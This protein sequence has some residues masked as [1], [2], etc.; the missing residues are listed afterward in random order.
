MGVFNSEKVRKM[1]ILVTG[2]NG[3][4][5][6]HLIDRLLKEGHEI[7]ALVRK[8]GHREKDVNWLTGD[9]LKPETLPELPAIDKAFYLVHGLKE[10][11]GSFEY[12]EA[13]A[14]VNFLK[15][16]R[17]SKPDL[18]YL[19]GII[20][21]DK[22]LSPHLR[23][24]KLCGAILGS[25]GLNLIEFRASIVLGEGS[26]SFEMIKALSER[27]PVLP[28]I[29]LL[30]EPSQPIGLNDLMDYLNE[31]LSVKLEGHQVVEIGGVGTK[32]YGELLELYASLQGL[33]RRKLKLPHL[34]P[35]ILMKAL[36]YSIPEHAKIGSKLTESLE[37]ATVVQSHRA[38][39]IFPNVRPMDL[40]QA[41]KN[42]IE[43]SKT[44]YPPIWE[45]DF[46]K[47]L[48]NEK[49][50]QETL[51]PSGLAGKLDRLSQLRDIFRSSK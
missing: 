48:L 28:D 31:A 25:S 50:I 27:F 7:F 26:L 23:S 37:H 30:T 1:K 34:D 29:P 42:A 32:S 11:K 5:G 9:L 24:R 20:P 13:M 18:I 45:K 17:K 43:K 51:L 38:R 16:V 33:K 19:G 4:V 39:E 8:K 35:K 40:E 2:A 21:E 36:D 22:S 6:S 41:M 44:H 10:E 3:F 46:I 14:A 15:W 47:L 12:A 49:V